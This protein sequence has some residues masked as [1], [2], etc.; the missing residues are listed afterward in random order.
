MR[1]VSGRRPELRGEVHTRQAGH[2]GKIGQAYTFVEV[3]F[4]VLLHAFEPPLGQ[5]IDGGALWF[6]SGDVHDQRL[7]DALGVEA[8]TRAAALDQR[9]AEHFRQ[10]VADDEI[11]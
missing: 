11:V 5:G 6:K 10:R 7:A 8:V 3:S 1:P 9:A 4:D 2:S